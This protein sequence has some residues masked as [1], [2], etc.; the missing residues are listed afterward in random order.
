[1]KK[2][3]NLFILKPDPYLKNYQRIPTAQIFVDLWNLSDWYAKDFSDA[4]LLK[5]KEKIGL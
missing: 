5:I 3:A 1:L 2:T 4:L